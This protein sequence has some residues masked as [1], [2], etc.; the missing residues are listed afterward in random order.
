M[1]LSRRGP[2][3]RSVVFDCD[4]TLSAI[5]GI[6]ELA[7]PL[8]AEIASLTDAAMRGE[9]PLEEVYGR[10]LALVRPSRERVEA[11]GRQYVERVVPGAAEA[12]AALRRA[13]VVV[14]AV[15]GG[16]LPAIHALTRSLG[17][18][19]EDVAAV[20]VCFDAAGEYAG[21]D[22]ASPLARTGG[23]AEVL[24]R[25]ARE[26]P[27]P[28]LMVGDGVTDLEARPPAD[29]FLAFTGVATRPGVV[30]AADHA[31]GS[32]AEVVALVLDG[33]AG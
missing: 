28:V 7:G 30:A 14:R 17:L 18:T 23:K 33:P 9:V 4:S 20:G 29:A 8:K 11:L 22:V 31:S 13:G 15:S 1:T 2:R 26:L 10:R 5:E 6:D 32:M 12:V 16:L 21:F 19:D 24:R 27:R 3:Y 25:W